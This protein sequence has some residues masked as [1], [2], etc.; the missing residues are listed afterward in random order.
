MIGYVSK[1]YETEN[2]KTRVGYYGDSSL[3]TSCIG[4]KLDIAGKVFK[5]EDAKSNQLILSPKFDDNLIDSPIY[6]A[7]APK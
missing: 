1:I 2:D 7:M 4:C 5:L 6:Y 3:F